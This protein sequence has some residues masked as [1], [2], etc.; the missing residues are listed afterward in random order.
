MEA[1]AAASPPTLIEGDVEREEGPCWEGRDA[2][3]AEAAA[4]DWLLVSA[5]TAQ[6]SFVEEREKSQG[7]D[8]LK[9]LRFWHSKRPMFL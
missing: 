5:P 6:E 4:E 9:P 2:A 8:M 3:T 7:V 1:E